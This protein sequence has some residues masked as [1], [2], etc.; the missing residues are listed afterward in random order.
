MTQPLPSPDPVLDRIERTRWLVL[1]PDELAFGLLRPGVRIVRSVSA[2]NTVLRGERPQVAV[3]AA[4]PGGPTEVELLITERRNRPSLTVALLTPPEEVATRLAALAA[5]VDEALPLDVTPHELVGRLEQRLERRRAAGNRR[6]M[7]LCNGLELD[8]A[9]RA[10]RRGELLQH[11][12]PK[13]F[14]LLLLLASHPGRTFT[15]AQLIERIWGAHREV[16]PR[17][18]DVHVRWL[19]EKLEVDPA[20]PSALLTV[21]GVGY[22]LERPPT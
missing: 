18:V 22:L 16:D 19:R 7:R 10:L 20:R 4:P 15:R 1:A 6:L 14:Q 3:L 17:T 21:R 12:R 2:F 8:V 11:L 9:A 5:G 13:E